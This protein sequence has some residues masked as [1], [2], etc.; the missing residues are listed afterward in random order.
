MYHKFIFLFLVALCLS[1]EHEQLDDVDTLPPIAH[2][3]ILVY[4]AADNNLYRNALTDI[5]EMASCAIPVNNN[6]L[7]YLDAPESS[8]D[9]IPKLFAIQDGQSVAVKQYSKQNSASGTVLQTV[10]ND[11]ISAFPAESYGLVLWSHGTGWLPADVYK[12]LP[13]LKQQMFGA[14]PLSFGLDGDDEMNISELAAAL[15][16]KFEFILFDACL[17]GGIEVYYQ[18]RDKSNI[19]IASPT[20]TLVAGFPYDEI[21]PFLFAPVPAYSEAA[22][23]YMNYYKHK[24]G[25]MQTATIAVVSTK[26]LAAFAALAGEV[27][28]SD[29]IRDSINWND[30]QR[31]DQ[32]KQPIFF[33]LEDYLTHV[34]IDVYGLA[35]LRQQLSRV[36]IYHDYTPYFLSKFAIEKSCGISICAAVTNSLSTSYQLLDWYV[37]TNL[38]AH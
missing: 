3:T 29:G 4:M 20:E 27:T 1:C 24:S 19:I 5:K 9:S 34:V 12:G 31:Y 8:T 22:N 25:E 23:A 18:L 11:A 21:V 37:A 15:P 32:L 7:V 17:M 38:S 33:D 16:L 6:L 26:E 10:I 2:R 36:V 28:A 30:I 13:L 14:R 35:A